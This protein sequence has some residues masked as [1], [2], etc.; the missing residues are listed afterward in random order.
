MTDSLSYSD[1]LER[2]A[3]WLVVAT[4]VA[5][6]LPTAWVG[7]M[8]GLFL[9][10][11]L[12]SGRALTYGRRLWA[13][14]LGRIALLNLLWMAVAIAWT[15]ADWR[16][17]LGNWWQYR[18][19][20]I[21]PLMLSV[22][23]DAKW[24]LR[25]LFGFLAGFAF[26][27]GVSYLR[28]LHVLPEYEGGG[29]LSGFGGRAGFSV[30]LAFAAYAALW[31]WRAQP[32]YRVAWAVLGVLSLFNLFIINDGR[33]GQ[34][35]FLGLF[36]LLLFRWLRWRGLLLGAL[37]AVLFA[38]AVYMVSP[39][40]QQR[41]AEVVSD[42]RNYRAGNTDSSMGLRVEF[43]SHTAPF[44]ARHPLF[45]GGTGSF[46]YE[47]QTLATQK[48]WVKDHVT[49]NPHNEYLMILSQ[50]GVIGLALLL[51]L[52][53]T[54]WRLACRMEELPRYLTHGLLVLMVLGDFFNCFI[55]DN[56]E[57]HLYALLTVAL[58]AGWVATPRTADA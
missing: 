23:A 28:W 39:R 29:T 18:E 48:G 3:Q 2:I 42:Y 12:A 30:M 17:G 10:V 50:Q 25:V 58:A 16:S 4:A 6:P 33:T 47:Y 41:G 5:I 57:G 20:L 34:I 43:W 56:L 54:Q 13:H 22:F 15:P 36:P 14:P 9:L 51:W 7:A 45:G 37:G 24:G 21:I 27:L 53:G 52:W 49:T 40:V 8:S 44:I 11:W 31:L 35:G 1:R 38:G 19:F 46:R 26:S 32:R 55:L